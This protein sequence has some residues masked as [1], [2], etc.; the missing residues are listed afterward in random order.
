MD[1]LLSKATRD[2]CDI[3]EIVT[4]V[5]KRMIGIKA[6]I[7]KILARNESSG[8]LRA[9]ISERVIFWYCTGYLQL[10]TQLSQLGRHFSMTANGI[11]FRR[12]QTLH[13]L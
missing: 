10:K 13:M 5:N 3:G 7:G 11:Q 9:T 6:D 2:R 8:K 4:T 12:L 1:K